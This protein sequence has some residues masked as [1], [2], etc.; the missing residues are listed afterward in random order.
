MLV[1]HLPAMSQ[2]IFR[3]GLDTNTVSVYLLCCGLVDTGDTLSKKS[4]EKIWNGTPEAL[5]EGLSRLKSHRII[6]QIISNGEDNAV[7]RLNAD[8]QWRGPKTNSVS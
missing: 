8:T 4:L 3:F 7:Y 1:N 6:Y 5:N 2:K